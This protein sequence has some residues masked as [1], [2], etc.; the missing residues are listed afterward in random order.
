MFGHDGCDLGVEQRGRLEPRFEIALEGEDET[1][2]EAQEV[3]VET[4]APRSGVGFCC[5]RDVFGDEAELFEGDQVLVDRVRFRRDALGDV[6][7]GH[8]AAGELFEDGEVDPWL[9][10]FLVDDA[11]A[12]VEERSVAVQHRV[13]DR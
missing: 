2:P 10:E 12:L 13:A 6:V 5:E 7:G 4:P 3:V 1:E 9:A 8:G 11:A